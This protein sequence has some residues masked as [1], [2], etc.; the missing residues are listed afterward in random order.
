MKMNH[1]E[2]YHKPQ[3]SMKEY[4]L[5][6]LAQYLILAVCI[7]LHRL[8]VNRGELISPAVMVGDEMSSPTMGRFVFCM[9]AFVAAVLLAVVASKKA[10]EGKEYAPFFL[11]LFAGTF[12][13]QSIGE[14]LWNFSVNGV[15]F[16]Q[17]E[18]VSVFPIFV[19]TLLFVVYAV[20]NHAL[21]FGMWCVLA[22]FLCNW[23]GH[24]VMLGTYPFVASW[25]AESVWNK[26]IA[27]VSGAVLGVVGIYLGVC[28]AK[29]RKGRLFASIITYIA[30]GIIAFG[31]ME[32]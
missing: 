13:W 5:P 9:G 26:S 32:G 25:F 28:S 30:T 17:L 27:Y 3:C 24:Y 12:L 7:I 18:S 20:R 8:F 4:V 6:F 16:V 15:N 11:G 19:I 23:A 31:M 21:D 14:D 1:Y 29:D 22:G 10:K 2:K